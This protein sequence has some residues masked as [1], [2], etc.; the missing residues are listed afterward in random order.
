MPGRLLSGTDPVQ[1]S[2]PVLVNLSLT[3]K[4]AAITLLEAAFFPEIPDAL[5]DMMAQ[6]GV[7]ECFILQTCNRVELFA[8]TNGEDA[9]PGLL[10]WWRA[11]L[12]DMADEFDEAVESSASRDAAS[13]GPGKT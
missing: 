1:G 2:Q 8:L 12:D 4:K 7:E 13:R 6:E 5:N 11:N 9:I 3:H 10:Q